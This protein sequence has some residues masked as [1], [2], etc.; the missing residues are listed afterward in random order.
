MKKNKLYIIGIAL[1]ATISVI[2]LIFFSSNVIKNANISSEK[3]VVATTNEK[4]ILVLLR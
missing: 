3:E 4:N 2:A 1:F